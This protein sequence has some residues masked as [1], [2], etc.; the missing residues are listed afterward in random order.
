MTEK[1]VLNIPQTFMMHEQSG[2]G[3]SWEKLNKGGGQTRRLDADRRMWIVVH[4]AL[5]LVITKVNFIT[6][7]TVH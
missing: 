3:R 5:R 7:T 4:H 2:R 1:T 6:V